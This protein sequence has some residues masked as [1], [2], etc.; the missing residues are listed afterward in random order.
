[1]NQIAVLFRNAQHGVS[2]GREGLDAVLACTA[3][4]D[5]ISVFF[6]GDGVYQ[7]MAGQQPAAVLARDYTPTFKLFGLYDIEQVFLCRE[8]LVERQ[9][10]AEQLLF[11]VQ[12]LSRAEIQSRLQAHSVR[13]VF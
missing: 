3:L 6:I 5:E 13:L 12:I 2:A 7:L 4:T 1:M 10:M 9:L 11:P 8:S